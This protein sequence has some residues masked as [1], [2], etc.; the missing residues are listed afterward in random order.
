[1]S[2]ESRRDNLVLVY[3]LVKCYSEK[4]VTFVPKDLL[5][6]VCRHLGVREATAKDYIETLLRGFIGHWG[7]TKVTYKLRIENGVVVIDK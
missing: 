3:Q 5:S 7:P 4:G 6:E 1:M 2:Y